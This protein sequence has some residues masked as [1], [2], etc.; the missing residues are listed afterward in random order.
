[1]DVAKYVAFSERRCTKRRIRK[2]SGGWLVE[3]WQVSAR[4]DELVLSD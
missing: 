2:I 3:E 4:Q 1:M